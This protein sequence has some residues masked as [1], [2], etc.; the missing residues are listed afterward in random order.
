MT[1]SNQKYIA[2]ILGGSGGIGLATAKKLA[3]EGMH[4]YIVY[5]DRKAEARA[6]EQ[7]YSEL[8]VEH[9]IEILTLNA[10]AADNSTIDEACRQLSTLKAAGYSVRLL[11]Q[12][13][14]KGNLKPLVKQSIVERAY[15]NETLEPL[16]RALEA[17][18]N[19]HVHSDFLL[20]SN[21]FQLTL[22]N[23]ALSL[24]DWVKGL[25]ES[26]L[27][28][29]D[30]RVIGLSSE[31][32]QKAWVNYAAVSATKAALEA[33]IRSIALEYAPYGIRANIIQAGVTDTNSLRRIPGADY[34]KAG[35]TFRNP[36]GRL[37]KPE[38]VAN[39]IYLLCRDE[40]AWI[41]G[42]LIKVDGGESLC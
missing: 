11:L 3:A 1:F 38:D 22:Q 33:I 20:D 42:A 14:S 35:A 28:A 4:L 18:K 13:V 17:E 34:L 41:N 9:G 7:F 8:S 25:H 24:I 6:I 19:S 2:L 40:A 30:A 31:G 39:A 5:R 26:S 16:Y 21:D 36:Y 37:T 27:F 15:E 12:S 32:N 29:S 10:D 23:M